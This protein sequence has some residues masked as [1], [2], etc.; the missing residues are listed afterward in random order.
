MWMSS[1]AAA[2]RLSSKPM[3]IKPWIMLNEDKAPGAG[4][5]RRVWVDIDWSKA[6]VGE[7]QGAVTISGG[8]NAP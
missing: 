5:D 4:D 7:H 8:T 1:H 2:S 6:P 3:P